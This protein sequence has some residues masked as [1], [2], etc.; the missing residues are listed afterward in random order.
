MVPILPPLVELMAQVALAST[1][2][3]R[4]AENWNVPPA[5]T[6]PVEGV[7]ARPCPTPTVTMAV[8]EVTILVLVVLLG[9]CG[10]VAVIITCPLFVVGATVGAV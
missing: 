8:F 6:V 10:A 5:G 2:L 4:S 9:T 7:T 1:M 3:F